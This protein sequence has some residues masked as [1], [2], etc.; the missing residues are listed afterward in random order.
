MEENPRVR[1][2][3]LA[4]ALSLSLMTTITGCELNPDGSGEGGEGD[5]QG[6]VMEYSVKLA[7]EGGF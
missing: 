7:N 1:L 4:L 2:T 5:E 3:C 6:K